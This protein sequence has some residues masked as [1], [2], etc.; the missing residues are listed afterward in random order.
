MGD[1]SLKRRGSEN[2]VLKDISE[3][4]D[5]YRIAMAQWHSNFLKDLQCSLN[6]TSDALEP[7]ISSYILQDLNQFSVTA[8]H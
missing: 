1:D 8:V 7:L 6:L 5:Q 2:R 4:K 3:G